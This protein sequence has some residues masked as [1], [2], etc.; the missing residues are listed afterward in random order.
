MPTPE[1][2]QLSIVVNRP[3]KQKPIVSELTV[4]FNDLLP[5]VP[6]WER[7]ANNPLN[8]KKR[9]AGWPALGDKIYQN[10]SSDNFA[11]V[12]LMDGTLHKI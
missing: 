5:C 9:V 3:A 12:L 7:F 8:D 1:F 11:I 2:S 6:L 10:A 4:A